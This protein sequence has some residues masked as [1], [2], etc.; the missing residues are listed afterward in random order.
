M[1]RL[2]RNIHKTGFFHIMVQGIN[3]SYIFQTEAQKKEYIK[4]MKECNK[5]FDIKIIA[6]CIMD[7]HSHMI[8]YS[9]HIAN[10]SKYMKSL[11]TSYGIYYNKTN[12]RIGFVFRNRFQSQYIDEQS[13]LINC[14]KY[15][16]MNPVKAGKELKEED[17]KYSSYNEYFKNKKIILDKEPLIEI[18]GDEKNIL[19]RIKTANDEIEVMDIERDEENFKI[20]MQEYLKENKL[21]LEEIKNN[22]NKIIDVAKYLKKKKYKQ[23][24]LAKMLHINPKTLSRMLK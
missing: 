1:P 14:I 19:K 23:V 3:K 8:I 7:N 22:K 6:Y 21:N 10:I 2:P 15:I 24:Q 4:L 17:Y 20:A 12:D 9:E 13:Y 5:K 16:H 11:N 18:F